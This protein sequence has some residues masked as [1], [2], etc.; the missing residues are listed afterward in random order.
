MTSKYPS[1]M[2]DKIFKIFSGGDTETLHDIDVVESVALG[3]AA[4]VVL[5][6]DNIHTFD[7]VVNQLCRATG[8]SEG[9]ADEKANEVHT[10]GKAIVHEG[11]LSECLK[12]TSILEEI[13]L[14]TQIEF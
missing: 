14:H 9:E 5:F 4:K 8:C 7:E 10:R 6:N 1:E 2:F 12:V 11:D 3:N 13:A